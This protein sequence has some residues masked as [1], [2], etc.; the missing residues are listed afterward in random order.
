LG[1]HS[2]DAGIS[3]TG[4]FWVA[5]IPE[6]SVEVQLGTGEASLDVTN[7]LVIDAFTVQNSL[8]PTHPMDLAPGRIEALHLEWSGVTRRLEFQDP[9]N[10]FAGLFLE[11]S[12]SIA[13]T[14]TTLPGG[15][16]HGFTF[17]SEATT[18]SNFAEVGR[19]RNGVFFASV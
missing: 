1:P 15:E 9:T 2:Y 18:A 11:N 16:R 3:R 13:V 7:L 12:A 5:R 17:T 4:V 19:D 6:E 14:A 8:D 10:R